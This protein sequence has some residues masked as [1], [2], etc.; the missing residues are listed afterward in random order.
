MRVAKLIEFLSL[1][2]RELVQTSFLFLFFGHHALEP[3]LLRGRVCMLS[4]H[5][6][7]LQ[8]ACRKGKK[9]VLQ[10]ERLS[11]FTGNHTPSQPAVT[12]R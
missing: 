12:E 7:I 5:T 9:N 8:V 1:G 2:S 6:P 10:N 11:G 4:C 3:D